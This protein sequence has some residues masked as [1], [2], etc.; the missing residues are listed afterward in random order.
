MKLYSILVLMVL[1]GISCSSE[2][3][4]EVKDDSGNL[5]ER[6]QVDK[7]GVKN[8]V[9]EYYNA[10]TLVSKANYS[11]GIQSGKRVIFYENGKPE[12]EEN[13][14]KGQ[15]DGEYKVFYETGEL[16]LIMLYSNNTIQGQ[17]RK[18]YPSG[19]LMEDVAFIDNEENGPFV[20]YWE[21]GNLK[22]Q[23]AYLNGDNEFGELKK[24]N[25]NGDLV[26]KLM[27]DSLAVCRTFWTLEGGPY[28][29]E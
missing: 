29:E 3:F 11:E 26:R 17:V 10:G 18:F 25:E 8:G 5:V 12:I 1:I 20:E 28:N 21:N 4:V 15:L 9:Y 19:Q 7:E 24:Y 6:Y 27:C 14:V 16:K 2:R 23:G 13:Y 22:W